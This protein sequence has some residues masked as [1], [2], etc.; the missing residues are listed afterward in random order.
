MSVPFPSE[1]LGRVRACGAVAVLVI[2]DA[3]DALPLAEAL[4]EGGIDVLEL[5]LRTPAAL[6]ALECIKKTFPQMIVGAGTI[7]TPEQARAAAEAGADF[8]VAPGL[9]P[10]VLQAADESGL[11]F[12]PGIM[13]PSEIEVAINSGRRLLKFFP[14][15]PLGGM[16]F[17]KSIAAPYAHLGLEYMPLG[18]LSLANIDAYVASPLVLALGGSWIAKREMIQSHAWGKIHQ[19]AI[20]ARER[21]DEIRAGLL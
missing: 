8:G 9:S 6:A 2:D 16:K 20:D 11:P 19:N 21:I 10:S 3:D 5:T 4:L 14:A 13:T 18:G 12:A 7:L 17:L 1:I 15:E